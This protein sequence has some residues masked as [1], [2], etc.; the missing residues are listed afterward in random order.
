MDK[1]RRAL[2]SRTPST[3]PFSDPAG[4]APGGGALIGPA[5]GR[6]LHVMSFNIRCVVSGTT[7]GHPDHWPDRAPLVQEFLGLEQ[8]TLLGVQEA[9]FEQ[10][11]AI[12]AACR[13]GT[14]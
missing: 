14:G 3:A 13:T 12:Q 10:L 2:L 1:S 5:A 11:A 8:P 9:G 4:A 6:D 7:P